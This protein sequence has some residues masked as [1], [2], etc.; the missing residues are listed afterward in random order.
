MFASFTSTWIQCSINSERRPSSHAKGRKR[1]P[2]F[3][4]FRCSFKGEKWYSPWRLSKGLPWILS[5]VGFAAQSLLAALGSIQFV[6]NVFFAS[7]VLGEKVGPYQAFYS[8]AALKNVLVWIIWTCLGLPQLNSMTTEIVCKLSWIIEKTSLAYLFSLSPVP[9]KRWAPSG[10]P[11]RHPSSSHHSS[12]QM[13]VFILISAKVSKPY[14]NCDA[15]DTQGLVCYYVYCGRLCPP[16]QLW[17]PSIW[18]PDRLWHAF[19]LCQ[20]DI[21]F[22]LHILY[23]VMPA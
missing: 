15:G 9:L 6:S 8:V 16:C 2:S 22:H 18:D 20:V 21:N 12:K 4:L 10:S 14:V 23:S 7:A 3:T 17:K 1:H 11:S 19:L 5:H 13:T